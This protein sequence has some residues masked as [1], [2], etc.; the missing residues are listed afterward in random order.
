VEEVRAVTRDTRHS[1]GQ[2][3]D[4]P[5]L[6]E[7]AVRVFRLADAPHVQLGELAELIES[8]PALTGKILRLANS[9]QLGMV[10]PVTTVMRAVATMGLAAVKSA[11]LSIGVFEAFEGGQAAADRKPLWVHSLGVACGAADL[12]RL[13]SR[14]DPELAFAAGLLHDI[15]KIGIAAVAKADYEELADRARAARVHVER[16]E[17][18]RFGIDH[19]ECGRM[20]ARRW[21][22][23]RVLE[24]VVRWHEPFTE[25]G[26]L[27][28][29]E[30]AL[31]EM[32]Q[33]AGALAGEQNIGLTTDMTTSDTSTL[34][35]ELGVDAEVVETVRQ[36]L[37]SGIEQRARILGLDVEEH[38]IYVDA[39][40]RANAQ[41]GKLYEELDQAR[42]AGERRADHFA[43]LH[44]THK[45]IHPGMTPGEI[46][47]IMVSNA[48]GLF[49]L[50]RAMMYYHEPN[51]REVHAF[52]CGRGEDA[53]DVSFEIDNAEGG[54]AEKLAR[55]AIERLFA[56]EWEGAEERFTL[57]PM[58]L[59]EGTIGGLAACGEG[60]LNDAEFASLSDLEALVDLGALALDRSRL[61]TRLD[62][63]LETVLAAQRDKR[64]LQ[65]EVRE[66]EKLA[67]LGRMA[68][69][70]AH[71]MNNPLAIISGRAQMLK[72]KER[73]PKGTRALETI[74]DQCERLS[75]IISDLL[76][77]ARPASPHF[78]LVSV[79]EALSRVAGLMEPELGQG[80]VGL[81]VQVDPATPA[82]FKADEKQLEQVLMNFIRN[83]RQAIEE[84]G[85]RGQIELLARCDESGEYVVIEVRDTGVGIDPEDAPHIFEPFY[86][87]K[88]AGR[89][90]GLGL[91]IAA[92]IVSHHG[93]FVR[94]ESEPGVSTTMYSYWP[95]EGPEGDLGHG[96]DE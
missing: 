18:E 59:R 73:E 55:A 94:V 53:R 30:K 4:L 78:T 82:E 35:K 69:G 87:T 96:G 71:E 5:T 13:T 1:I 15:G 63:A 66:S 16:L 45:V 27:E 74:I 51:G 36:G 43:G 81:T 65:R 24:Q 26:F 70:A 60:I 49:G 64:Q 93:G 76:G 84:K 6:P 14:I 33:L 41:L 77:Y 31:V 38:E 7:I 72:R 89:G 37:G 42:R 32:V 22:L 29:G 54:S 10:R 88:E 83:A 39:V 91:S 95:V 12:A 75:H 19:I 40:R 9:A 17:R 48:C 11:V 86:S 67:A 56:G 2:L 25:A 61:N 28:A 57:I 90:T 68:A 62:S 80:E 23:P 8:D 79:Q 20:L 52:S 47:G 3:D 21:T 92:S 34:A 44:L 46:L 85:E 50:A 58:K